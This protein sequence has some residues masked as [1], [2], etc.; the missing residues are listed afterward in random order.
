MRTALFWHES[1]RLRRS[2]TMSTRDS[3]S[4]T[5]AS[6]TE[7][8]SLVEDLREQVQEQDERIEALEAEN[9][10][11]RECV[12][13]QDG[14]IDE[15]EKRIEQQ[16]N[17]IEELEGRAHVEWE[18][19]NP[20][21]IT[22][23]DSEGTNSVQPY[24]AITNRPSFD[25]FEALEGRVL[26]LEEAAEAVSNPGANADGAASTRC[27]QAETPLEQVVAMPEEMVDEQLTANQERARFVATDVRDYTESV[28]AGWMISSS[29]LRRVLGAY[30]DSGHTET[31]ARVF[32]ILDD[33]GG[34]EVRVVERRGTKRVVFD[35]ALVERLGNLEQVSH[36]VVMAAEA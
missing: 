14:R 16:E 24:R 34:E 31:V 25:A 30:D 17:R 2:E 15:Q 4:T 36:S 5:D 27:P 32:D 18:G 28:P 26:E 1:V 33:L 6:V 10:R 3:Q 29:D 22:I 23:H 20:A 8:A 19:P 21:E 11:L 9:E 7:L 35:D 13:D 12:D